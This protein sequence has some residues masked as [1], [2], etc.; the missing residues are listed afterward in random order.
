MGD[1]RGAS[2]GPDLFVRGPV[3]ERDDV[4]ALLHARKLQVKGFVIACMRALLADPDRFLAQLNQY[5]PE[6]R[7]AGRPPKRPQSRNAERRR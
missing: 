3:P 7:R 5:W 2:E 4:Q 1:E 6:K